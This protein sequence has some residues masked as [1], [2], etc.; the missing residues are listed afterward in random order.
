[1][2]RNAQG[3]WVALVPWMDSHAALNRLELAFGRP[4]QLPFGPRSEEMFV[5]L[6]P[7]AVVSRGSRDTVE[8]MHAR[9]QDIWL[10]GV[11]TGAVS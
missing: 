7:C 11:R 3:D 10:R 2:S 5:A 8:L 4:V 6:T 9:A 1:V